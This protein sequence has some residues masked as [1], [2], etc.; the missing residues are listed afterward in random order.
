MLP[1]GDMFLR[2]KAIC[3]CTTAYGRYLERRLSLQ[4]GEQHTWRGNVVATSP[5]LAHSSR[6]ARP[7]AKRRPTTSTASPETFSALLRATDYPVPNS[8]L[9]LRVSSRRGG[10]R[11]RP[12]SAVHIF[13]TKR[14][15]SQ[16]RWCFSV[17]KN[18]WLLILSDC[19]RAGL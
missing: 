8:S 10:W 3:N 12:W 4:S 5:K 14:G 2:G 11:R 13:T 9:A 1:V 15:R 7:A 17:L 18:L 6:T 16:I 19:T